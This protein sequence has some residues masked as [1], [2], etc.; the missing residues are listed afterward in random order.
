MPNNKLLPEV[1]TLT[2]LTQDLHNCMQEVL[3]VL[4]LLVPESDLEALG[5][6][7]HWLSRQFYFIP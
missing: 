3:Y 1:G 2:C 5:Q 6:E 7:K 4:H